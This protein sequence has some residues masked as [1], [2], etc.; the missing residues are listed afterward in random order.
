MFYSFSLSPNHLL[1][2]DIFFCIP[3]PITCQTKYYIFSYFDYIPQTYEIIWNFFLFFSDILHYT[4]FSNSIYIAVNY[5]NSSLFIATDYSIVF[6]YNNF[7]SPFIVVHLMGCLHILFYWDSII[8][9]VLY[10]T[11]DPVILLLGVYPSKHRKFSMLYF[12]DVT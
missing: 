10:C 11:F 6:I 5:K 9:S 3:V 7:L 12:C 2:F 4:I 8:L 1:K